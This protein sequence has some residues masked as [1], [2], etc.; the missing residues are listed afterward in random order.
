[1]TDVRT[2][3]PNQGQCEKCE[4]PLYPC[5]QTKDHFTQRGVDMAISLAG[6]KAAIEA[7]ETPEYT[8]CPVCDKCSRCNFHMS[9]KKGGIS[10]YLEVFI[11]EGQNT[12]EAFIN[13]NKVGWRE[14]NTFLARAMPL[15]VIMTVPEEMDEDTRLELITKFVSMARN[16]QGTIV[17]APGGKIEPLL[18]VYEY[19]NFNEWLRA[20]HTD[21]I[22]DSEAIGEVWDAARKEKEPPPIVSSET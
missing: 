21:L 3:M 17:P 18:P 16:K 12:A 8:Y 4:G 22:G 10:Q 19:L 20:T 2:N 9:P 15:P 5:E 7:L 1:M 6:H 14:V 11:D 13:G